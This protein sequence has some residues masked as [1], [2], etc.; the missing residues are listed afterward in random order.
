L[1][2]DVVAISRNRAIAVVKSGLT[3]RGVVVGMSLSSLGDKIYRLV[4]FANLGIFRTIASEGQQ[5][6]QP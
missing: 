4:F 2:A 6:C 5:H 3:R 1:S